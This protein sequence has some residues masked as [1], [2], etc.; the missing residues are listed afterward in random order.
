MAKKEK[1]DKKVKEEKSIKHEAV[2]DSKPAAETAVATKPNPTNQQPKK[3]KKNAPDRPQPAWLFP[4]DEEN[5]VLNPKEKSQEQV[6]KEIEERLEAIKFLKYK[7]VSAPNK[8]PPPSLLLQ[9]VGAFLA[10]FGFNSTGRMFTLER[11]A[12]V[13]IA[14][15]EDEIGAKL[16]KGMPGLSKIFKDWHAEWDAV[17][18][19]EEDRE[20]TSSEEENEDVSD[21]EEEGSSSDSDD[22]DDSDKPT[23]KK[24]KA[25]KDDKIKTKANS[26]AKVKARSEYS[27]SDGEANV[28]EK[29]APLPTSEKPTVNG[30]LEKLKARQNPIAEEKPIKAASSSSSVSESD[31]KSSSSEEEEP[32]PKKKAKKSSKKEESKPTKAVKTEESK[33]VKKAA[34]TSSSEPSE[35][36]SNS[37][38]EGG[39]A[40]DANVAPSTDKSQSSG[41]SASDSSRTLVDELPKK[42]AIS[43]SSP[44]SNS[45]ESISD[46]DSEEKP[47][48]PVTTTVT[49][50][51]KRKRAGSPNA[52]ET[53]ETVTTKVAKK[54]NTPFQ[55]VAPDTKVDSKFASNKFVPYDY[56]QRA[57]EDLIVTRGKN[58]TKEKNKKKRGS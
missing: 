29:V 3:K 21:V 56:A 39:V 32:T 48:V 43:E 55:R 31:S 7:A 11:K 37:D 28:E 4:P 9:L 45:S 52:K 16:P 2:E 5:P 17:M 57:H 46:S 54:N 26:K 14:G 8:T 50:T 42:E 19:E 41:Q 1:K 33:K 22:S 40:A 25:K 38:S 10:E 35:S 18:K 6:K 24:A 23:K 53:T 34:S 58:F 30:L 36:S 13:R 27:S 44:V 47:A 12:R 20:S 15:W 49:K 51:T